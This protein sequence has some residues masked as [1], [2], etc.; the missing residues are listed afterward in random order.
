MSCAEWTGITGT[1]ALPARCLNI[2]WKLRGSIGIPY[3]VVSTRPEPC[4]A[5]ATAARAGLGCEGRCRLAAG[6]EGGEVGDGHVDVGS[7]GLGEGRTNRRGG[8]VLGQDRILVPGRVVC[9]QQAMVTGHRVTQ[10]DA[11][12]ACWAPAHA[13]VVVDSRQRSELGGERHRAEPGRGL[14]EARCCGLTQGGGPKRSK[15]DDPVLKGGCEAFGDGEGGGVDS[16]GD[17]D[18]C[19]VGV[20][21]AL[22]QPVPVVD[23]VALVNASVGVAGQR[24]H[25]FGGRVPVQAVEA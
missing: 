21:V 11:L 9:V 1:P 15:V 19:G 3:L 5:S 2:R 14:G 6:H 16:A 23:V 10:G 13:V 20:C 7:D 22:S 24:D 4:H 8:R 18:A 25:P 12:F 17:D